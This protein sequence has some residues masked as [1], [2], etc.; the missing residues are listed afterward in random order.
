MPLYKT[1]TIHT[2]FSLQVVVGKI[3]DSQHV[4]L[5]EDMT[6]AEYST[7]LSDDDLP[8]SEL[9]KFDFPQVGDL[10]DKQ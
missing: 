3:G 8:M 6:F 9:I 10:M 2:F 1:I 7:M 5:G 4:R